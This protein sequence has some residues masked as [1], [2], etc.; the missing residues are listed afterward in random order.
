MKLFNKYLQSSSH[1][2]IVRA[3]NNLQLLSRRDWEQI[4]NIYLQ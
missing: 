3:K 4:A 1:I 2:Y